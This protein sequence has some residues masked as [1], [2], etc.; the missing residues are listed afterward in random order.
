MKQKSLARIT[1]QEVFWEKRAEKYDN[2]DWVKEPGYIKNIILKS[3]FTK[4]DTVLDVGTGTG[5]IA[6]AIAPLIKAVIGL[7]ISQDMLKHTNWKDNKYFIKRDIKESLF[8]E[9]VFDK[10]T[11]RMVFHHIIEGTQDA[12]DECYK[13]LKKG[14]KM[15]ISE[16]VPPSKEVKQDYEDIFKLKET[17]LTF[18]PEDILELM[19]TSG[20]TNVKVYTY[21][22]KDFS[23]KNWLNNSAASKEN[24]DKIFDMHVNGSE[25]FKKEFN[26][27]IVD[28]DCLINVKHAIVVG[29]KI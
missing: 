28:G 17:R 1:D 6:H 24:Q 15:I 4:E 19:E 8:K 13:V 21:I 11:A 2:L 26:V 14:G 29:E 18:L 5:V 16:G 7:D 9:E 3:N 20:F 10:V 27:K 25:L 23:I 22:M 12:M